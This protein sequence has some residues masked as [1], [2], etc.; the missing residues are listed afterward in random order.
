[1][2]Y[3]AFLLLA[4]ACLSATA[5]KPKQLPLV[6][7]VLSD[8]HL[9]PATSDAF[10]DAEAIH[11]TIHAAGADAVDEDESKATPSADD[12]SDP[13]GPA[14]PVEVVQSLDPIPSSSSGPAE[15]EGTQGLDPHLGAASV[16]TSSVAAVPAD[17][18]DTTGTRAT[19]PATL[20]DQVPESDGATQLPAPG[21]DA[22]VPL[23]DEDDTMDVPNVAEVDDSQKPVSEKLAEAIETMEDPSIH[24]LANE[25]PSTGGA[26]SSSATDVETPPTESA[27]MP[28]ADPD[29]KAIAPPNDSSE[30]KEMVVQSVANARITFAEESD[31]GEA[32]ATTDE[33]DAQDE[34]QD[35]GEAAAPTNEDMETKEEPQ[36]EILQEEESQEEEELQEAPEEYEGEPETPQDSA[37]IKSWVGKLVTEEVGALKTHLSG[38][39]QEV[40]KAVEEHAATTD[41]REE[42]KQ[43]QEGP[44]A[45]EMKPSTSTDDAPASTS[46]SDSISTST[47][48]QPAAEEEDKI[49]AEMESEEEE[50][51]EVW[52][53][54]LDSTGPAEG[55]R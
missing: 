6:Q 15:E 2:A 40:R 13:T 48:D 37:H 46:S 49:Q 52:E 53:K 32:D 38:E 54:W 41:M 20:S 14:E 29:S 16:V 51:S 28:G 23:G 11:D 10:D 30:S 1:M 21:S 50:S 44:I 17:L 8:P 5:I 12:D 4:V 34:P 33:V 27:D 36:E 18:V 25:I 45:A 35:E 42:A 3:F 47:S 24:E 22:L 39:I 55:N 19:V 31:E 9:L 7:K 43:E 26:S